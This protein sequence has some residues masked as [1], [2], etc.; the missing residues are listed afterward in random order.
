[1]P[2]LSS[3]NFTSLR[4]IEHEESHSSKCG[5]SKHTSQFTLLPTALCHPLNIMPSWNTRKDLSISFSNERHNTPHLESPVKSL[6]S[7]DDLHQTT[8]TTDR[9]FRPS[10]LRLSPDQRK[11]SV[12]SPLFCLTVKPRWSRA[13]RRWW[14]HGSGRREEG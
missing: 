10:N 11:D 3:F 5:S 2:I 7:A 4:L 9:Q 13:L 8:D 6:T 1:M 14:Y 12:P